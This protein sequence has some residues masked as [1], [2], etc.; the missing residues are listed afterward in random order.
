MQPT[1]F[2]PKFPCFSV[3]ANDCTNPFTVTAD[4]K[5]ALAVFTSDEALKNY[6]A[7]GQAMGP[8]IRFDLPEALALYLDSLPSNVTTIAF[9]SDDL[10]K[11]VYVSAGDLYQAVLQRIKK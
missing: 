4:G 3:L 5:L 10:T 11:V 8:T 6:R 9:Y 1:K 2:E 7:T